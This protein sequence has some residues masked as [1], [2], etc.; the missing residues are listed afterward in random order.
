MYCGHIYCFKCASTI[1]KKCESGR[2]SCDDIIWGWY[3]INQTDQVNPKKSFWL[4]EK[5]LK[6]KDVLLIKDK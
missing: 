4:W 3:P 2:C 5:N 6:N 1:I